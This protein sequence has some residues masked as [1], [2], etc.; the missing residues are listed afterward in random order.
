MKQLRRRC[1]FLFLVVSVAML[2][3]APAL[4]H[5]EDYID[6]TLVFQT[7]DRH[8]F[9]PEYWFDYGHRRD[10]HEDFMRHHVSAEFGITNHWMLDARATMEKEQGHGLKFDSARAETRFRFSEE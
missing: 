2:R 3:A 6:E 1:S 4:A 7:L 9:E 8:E 10:T 5:R